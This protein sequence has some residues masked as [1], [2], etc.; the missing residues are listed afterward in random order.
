MRPGILALA[1][2]VMVVF[3]SAKEKKA[4]PTAKDQNDSVG[5]S[6]TLYVDRESIKE[7]LGDDLGGNYVV[8]AVTVKPRLDK[9]KI[10][11]DD[12]TL[13][14]G[15]DGEKAHPFNGYQIAG[16]GSLVVT[17]TGSVRSR[18]GVMM[19]DPSGPTWGG[20]PGTGGMP[21]RMPGSGGGIGNGGSDPGETTAKV[22]SG[23]GDK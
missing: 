9:V 19:G 1:L 3:A 21:Q 18:G 4:P 22:N 12:F 5:V 14:S 15:R 7:L 20:A 10:D 2:F 13:L 17:Q 6:G 16:R 8:M 23:A 11:Y